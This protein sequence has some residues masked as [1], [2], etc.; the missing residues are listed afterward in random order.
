ML[1]ME[2]DKVKTLQKL[3][4]LGMFNFINENLNEV[5]QAFINSQL[6]NESSQPTARR[7]TE[8][9]KAF[10]LSLYKRSPRLYV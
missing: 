1:K 4:D 10:A 5:T 2:K 8:Q 3:H 7:W 9:D 6:R